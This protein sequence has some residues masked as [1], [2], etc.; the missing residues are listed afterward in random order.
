M[1]QPVT[2]S[3]SIVV[4]VPVVADDHVVVAQVVSDGEVDEGV[5]YVPQA[6][7]RNGYARVP[8]A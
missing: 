4:G 7:N 6:G 5:T 1:G 3:G 2:T 8:T